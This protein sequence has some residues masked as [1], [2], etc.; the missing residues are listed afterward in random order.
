MVNTE[1]HGKT[2]TYFNCLILTV[3]LQMHRWAYNDDDDDD[4]VVVV[5]ELTD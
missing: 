5:V 1:S 3:G 2:N 4:V